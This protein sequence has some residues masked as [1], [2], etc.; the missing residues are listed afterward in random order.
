[1]KDIKSYLINESA[2]ISHDEWESISTGEFRANDGSVLVYLTE[3][4]TL[5][6]I[7][8]YKNCLEITL[9]NAVKKRE[10]TGTS[11]VNAIIEYAKKINKDIIVYAIPIGPFIGIEQLVNFYKDLGFETEECDDLDP[12]MNPDQLLRYKV[13]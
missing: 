7:K 8:D 11:L 3:A 10:G 2:D 6:F 5:P 1:M 4:L 9:L 13:K 12:H